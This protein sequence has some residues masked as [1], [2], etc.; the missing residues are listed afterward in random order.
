MENYILEVIYMDVL[1]GFV[2]G[3]LIGSIIGIFIAG[4]LF[5][6][7]D[8]EKDDEE[9]E[10]WIREYNSRRKKNECK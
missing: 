10:K 7:E 1:I 2:G 9:Q 4:L 5:S 6:T 3:I 8:K